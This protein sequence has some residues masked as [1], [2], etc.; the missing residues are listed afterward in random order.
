M[1]TKAATTTTRLRS[2]VW[3]IVIAGS[4]VTKNPAEGKTLVDSGFRPKPSG[5][6]FPN[7]CGD[8]Y[9]SSKLTPNDLVQLFGERVCVRWQSND[10]APT[11]GAMPWLEQQN[12]AMKGGHCEGMAALSSAF[13]V[14]SG[15]PAE[16]GASP[17]FSLTPANRELLASTSTYWVTQ[18][19][20]WA[21]TKIR[22]IAT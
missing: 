18:N 8:G 2:L 17:A 10:C 3:S 7:W 1:F 16:Y 20:D 21:L 9:S 12:A 22:Q 6:S 13:H 4:I 11:P 19:N 5:F 15:N 14:N